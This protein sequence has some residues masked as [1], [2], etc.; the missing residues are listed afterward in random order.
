MKNYD[1][2]AMG[3][4]GLSDTETRYISGGFFRWPDTSRFQAYF[5]MGIRFLF[6]DPMNAFGQGLT[7]GMAEGVKG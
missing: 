5:K 7:R 1:L 4:S 2:N 6:V 3:I